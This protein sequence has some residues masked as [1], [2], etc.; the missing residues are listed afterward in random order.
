MHCVHIAE[1]LFLSVIGHLG[2]FYNWTVVLSIIMNIDRC[3]C[4][5]SDEHFCF[6]E[7]DAKKWNCCIIQKLYVV[8]FNKSPYYFLQR[9][10][11]RIFPS[12]ISF[13]Y[14]M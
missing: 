11:K 5:F 7:L 4:I 8:I 12:T 1:L 9:K 13:L 2:Y 14:I 10:N 3:G 6:S